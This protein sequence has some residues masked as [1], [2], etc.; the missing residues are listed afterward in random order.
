M[1][2]QPTARVIAVILPSSDWVSLLAATAAPVSL[3]DTR[4]LAG[5]DAGLFA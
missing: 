1:P 5:Q 2:M 3:V 4:L